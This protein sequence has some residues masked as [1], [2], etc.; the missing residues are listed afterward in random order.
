MAGA[1]VAGIVV[2]TLATSGASALSKEAIK[3]QDSIAK[4]AAKFEQTKSK[5]LQ[6]CEDTKLKGTLPSSTV[7]QTEA[8]AKIGSA[9]SKMQAAIS[10]ACGGLSAT[11]VQF[12]TVCPDLVGGGCNNTIS[13]IG[14]ITTCVTCV[15]GAGVDQLNALSYASL[16]APGSDTNLEKC[17]QTLG[18]EAAAFFQAK[19]KALAACQS[20]V[21]KGST[22]GPCA[23]GK[24]RA[25]IVKARDKAA[26]KMT[27][28]CSAFS[29]PQIGALA[30]CPTVDTQGVGV[31]CGGTISSIADLTGCLTC[32][33]ENTTLCTECSHCGNGVSNSVTGLPVVDFNVGETCDDG[34]VVDSDGCPKGCTIRACDSSGKTQKV[35][36]SFSGSSV[37]GL[38]VFLR[39]GENAARIPGRANEQTVLDRVTNLPGSAFTAV[40]DLD[41]ALRVV[42]LSDA[43]LPAGTLFTAEFDTCKKPAFKVSDLECVVEDAADASSNPISGVT[44]SAAFTN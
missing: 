37:V 4:E 2:G 29:P 21:I 42:A 12:G 39:Y 7:C 34:N 1:V 8:A 20:G 11:D 33:N 27:A 14:D 15:I 40:N 44:C 30:A 16:T 31:A 43:A 24:A 10:K 41:Y 23:D 19:S 18:K 9:Q 28:A 6:K 35:N 26:A 32:A 17:K 36:V 5:E 38:T 25:S 22:G 13:T 3:C